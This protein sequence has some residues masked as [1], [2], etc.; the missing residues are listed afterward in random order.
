ME[1]IG[2]AVES[3]EIRALTLMLAM[4]VKSGT[5]VLHAIESRPKVA[6]TVSTAVM[7]R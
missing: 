6:S 4:Q 1:A 2:G 7:A 5:N 3:N